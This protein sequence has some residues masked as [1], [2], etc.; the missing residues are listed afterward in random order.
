MLKLLTF[1]SESEINNLVEQHKLAPQ[2]HI[3][4][5]ALAEEITK[6]VHKQTGLQKAQRLTEAF[7]TG[8]LS[9]L[10]SDLLK[11][12]LSSL[13]SIEL[14]KD[15]KIIDALIR[16][17]A[18]TSKREAREFINAK[19]IYVNDQLITDENQLLESFDLLEQKYLLIKK[20]KRKYFLITLK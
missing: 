12:A 17:S 5:K 9:S 3:M 15:V 1:L 18:A 10:T 7:F 14:E 8:K 19:A 20:G 6:F 13:K 16:V 4:Q 11:T 2:K